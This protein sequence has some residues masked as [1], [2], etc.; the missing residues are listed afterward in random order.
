MSDHNIFS[1][2]E[3]IGLLEKKVADLEYEIEVAENV[4]RSEAYIIATKNEHVDLMKK[5][6][7]LLESQKVSGIMSFLFQKL[8]LKSP[9]NL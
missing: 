3:K 8:Y 2:Q 7:F 6:N 1:I 4:G 5:E 9:V